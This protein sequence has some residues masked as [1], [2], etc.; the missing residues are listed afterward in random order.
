MGELAGRVW[1]GAPARPSPARWWWHRQLK[2]PFF[3]RFKQPWRWPA[4]VDAEGWSRVSI[5]SGSHSTLSAIVRETTR[6]RPLGVVVCAHPMGLAAKGFWLRNG[7]ADVLL[8]AGFHVL[9]FDFN[10]FGESPSTN[11]DWPADAIAAGRF[12]RASFPGLP[13][14][15]LAA[16]FGAMHVLNATPHPAFPYDRIV[17]EGVAPSL[18]DFWKAYPVAHAVLAVSTALAPRVERA[19]RP[20][21]ALAAAHRPTRLLLIHSRGDD[22]T[23]VA[24]GERLQAVSK[25]PV[26]RLVLE[27]AEHTH[28]LRDEPF[29]WRH[30]VLGFLQAP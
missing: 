27:W 9:A 23:P 16:S 30:A 2:K 20:E 26:S 29:R 24:H 8:D 25:G 10:G 21:A 22:W 5:A 15:A 4:G 1:P 14:H 3:G 19:L 18:A 28:G 17:A 11:F 13:V 6:Q 7:H 12:A